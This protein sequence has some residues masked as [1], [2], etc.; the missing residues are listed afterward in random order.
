[1]RLSYFQFLPLSDFLHL[2]SAN[3]KI[4]SSIFSF[5]NCDLL[6]SSLYFI[7]YRKDSIF[8]ETCRLG[9]A[10]KARC[11]QMASLQKGSWRQ[12]AQEC[13]TSSGRLPC[14]D[15]SGAETAQRPL[16]DLK[17]PMTAEAN[18]LSAAAAFAEW[19]CFCRIPAK[20]Q[21]SFITVVSSGLFSPLYIHYFRYVKGRLTAALIINIQCSIENLQCAYS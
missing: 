17:Q 13:K 2:K 12:P 8:Y 9:T 16:Y 15:R 14:T 21:L 20:S 5:I 4:G 19:S 11:P 6:S 10:C 3:I 1:M 7:A 18:I